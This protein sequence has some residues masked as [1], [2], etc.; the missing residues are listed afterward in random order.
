[1]KVTAKISDTGTLQ[2]I[3]SER[4]KFTKYLQKMPP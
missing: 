1:M 2:V 4:A 3:D